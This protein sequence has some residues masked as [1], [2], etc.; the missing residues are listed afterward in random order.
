[1][2]GADWTRWCEDRPARTLAIRKALRQ[3]LL[4]VEQIRAQYPIWLCPHCG[5]RHR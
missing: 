2:T 3:S 5:E 4:T 1:M